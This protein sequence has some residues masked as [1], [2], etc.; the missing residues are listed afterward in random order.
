MKNLLAVGSRRLSENKLLVFFA[1][2]MLSSVAAMAASGDASITGTGENAKTEVGAIIR[3]VIWVGAFIP[4]G[5]PLWA[6]SKVKDWLANKE[7]QGQYEPKIMKMSKIAAAGFAGLAFSYLIL[8]FFG[9]VLV[10]LSFS[11]SWSMFVTDHWSSF[12][13]KS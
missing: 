3:A 11:E 7:E 4:I 5:L 13:T 6:M 8:G 12:L 2:F 10:G 1:L 9:G